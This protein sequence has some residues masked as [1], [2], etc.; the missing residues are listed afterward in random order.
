MKSL[1][2]VA[3]AGLAAWACLT[4]GAALAG[5]GLPVAFPPMEGDAPMEE[6]L[7]ERTNAARAAR[8]LA[9]L[10]PHQGL[11]L[12]AR[13]HARQMAEG[14]FLSH[15]SP[16]PQREDVGDR[17]SLAGVPLVEFGEN[18]ARVGSSRNV[19]R[20]SVDGWLASGAHRANLLST[21]FTHVGFGTARAD[22][23]AVYVAQVLAAQP[24]ER[25]EV[26]VRVE[27]ATIAHWTLRITSDADRSIAAFVD[28]EARPARSV[29]EGTFEL[30][31]TTGAEARTRLE[32]G[33]ELGSGRYGL[34]EAA[35]LEAATG[36]VRPDP[37]AP[38]RSVRIEDGSVQREVRRRA[39]V[40][41]RYRDP[42]DDLALFVSDEHRPEARRAPG[43]FRV[44]VPA[45]GE[46][47]ALEVG[48][49]DTR[50]RARILERFVLERSAQPRLV[51]GAAR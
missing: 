11:T 46:A 41:V 21:A 35:W 28:G 38:A 34:E 18:L 10:Q 9:V 2:R 42:P 7:L 20:E 47:L 30:D 23:G 22:D 40:E 5:S 31:L 24:L 15:A 16:D 51:A 44:E 6:A 29:S 8:G 13:H 32:L 37:S 50:G 27:E 26:A 17:L 1:R 3:W 49:A 36:E 48:V 4:W 12:A 19:A 33:V 14:N 45:H 39:I 43:T 25:A